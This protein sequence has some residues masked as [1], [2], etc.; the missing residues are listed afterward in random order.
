MGLAISVQPEVGVN[1]LTLSLFRQPT[2]C[3]VSS[4]APSPHLQRTQVDEASARRL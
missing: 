1:K 3:S 4:L 2:K